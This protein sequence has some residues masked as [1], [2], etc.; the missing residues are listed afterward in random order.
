MMRQ[1][2]LETG[3]EPSGSLAEYLKTCEGPNAKISYDE[4]N[5]MIEVTISVLRKLGT[6]VP[7]PKDNRFSY[8]ILTGKAEDSEGYTPK[9][10]LTIPKAL[11]DEY[12]PACCRNGEPHTSS[13]KVYKGR[14]ALITKASNVIGESV[15]F[16]DFG[17]G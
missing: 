12:L 7:I 15:H 10:L 17:I 9:I 4:R 14:I 6:V 16:I 3:I 2:M 13:V 11:D 5:G 8:Q 1:L